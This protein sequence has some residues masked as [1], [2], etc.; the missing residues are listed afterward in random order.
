MG[1]AFPRRPNGGC[2]GGACFE[3]LK[4]SPHEWAQALLASGFPS[5]GGRGGGRLR[6]VVDTGEDPHPVWRGGRAAA[7]ALRRDR[8][9]RRLSG[10]RSGRAGETID[11]QAP[12]ST[13]CPAPLTYLCVSPA[14]GLHDDV[15]ATRNAMFR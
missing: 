11:L 12:R 10:R 9:S 5:T 1:V 8:F 7:D 6:L 2:G 3:L 15:G 4:L 14:A 13:M